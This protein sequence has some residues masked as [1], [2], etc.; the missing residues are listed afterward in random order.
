MII[1]MRHGQDDPER[2]GG[3][4]CAGLT[5]EGRRQAR[6]AAE[7]LRT[8]YPG[9]RRI[10][11]SDLPRAWETAQIAACEFGLPVVPLP[12]FRETNNGLLAGMPKAEAREKY[13][14]IR[15]AALDFD[16][17]YPGGESPREFRD[18]IEAAWAEFSA[19][20]S[21]KPGDTL[22]VT[23]AGVINVILCRENGIPFTNRKLTFPTPCAGSVPVPHTM[24]EC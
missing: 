3:W 17:R 22:L 24:T 9:I 23:H 15:F 12:A 18:R 11:A 5:D 6:T 21:A 19:S 2:L 16:E 7:T 4:S 8:E 14:G 1:L 20:E 13:P 10:C